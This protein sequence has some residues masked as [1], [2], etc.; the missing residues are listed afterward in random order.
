MS[1]KIE[2]DCLS[3]SHKKGLLERAGYKIIVG[4]LRRSRLLQKEPLGENL[5]SAT[6]VL[7]CY[8]PW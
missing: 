7:S 4:G 8:T 6:Q 2:L 1:S 5:Y 3:G